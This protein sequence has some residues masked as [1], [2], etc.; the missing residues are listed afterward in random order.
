MFCV[1]CFVFCVV[2]QYGD[3]SESEVCVVL[4]VIC[5]N[6]NMVTSVWMFVVWL[7][8][9]LCVVAFALCV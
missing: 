2:A 3:L 7:P 8:G 4:G 9:P 6:A 5:V 1:L